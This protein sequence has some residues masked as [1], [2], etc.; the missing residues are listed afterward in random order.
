MTSFALNSTFDTT[1]LFSDIAVKQSLETLWGM[2]RDEANLIV[3]LSALGMGGKKRSVGTKNPYWALDDYPAEKTT[4]SAATGGLVANYVNAS[5]AYTET[6]WYG[7]GTTATGTAGQISL[8]EK[9]F[10]RDD[11]LTIT[12]SNGYSVQLRLG[13]FVSGTGPYMYDIAEIIYTNVASAATSVTFSSGETAVIDGTAVLFDDEA[14]SYLNVKPGVVYNYMQKFR[15]TVGKG[16]FER[17]EMTLANTTL[18]HLAKLGFNSFEKKRNNAL[19]NNKYFLAPT[20][21]GDDRAMFGGF[22]YIFD[23]HDS[24]ACLSTTYKGVNACDTGT[25]LDYGN[26]MTW[27]SN[28]FVKGSKS[29]M[30]FTSPRMAVLLLRA[31]RTEV[32]ITNAAYSNVHPDFPR[33]IGEVPSFETAFGRVYLHVDRGATDI[34]ARVYDDTTTTRVNSPLYWML[35]IDPEQAGIVYYDC[36]EAGGVQTPKIVNVQKTRNSTIDE[37]EFT[38]TMSLFYGDPQTGGYYGITNS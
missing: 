22:P 26:L 23:P 1:N 36:P 8:S 25:T 27:W 24:S 10:Y 17:G 35:G 4:I 2:T 31:I 16:Q 30:L 28:L 19:Y 12:D 32:Q 38:T 18:Q 6:N 34:R 37:I 15:E 7:G 3:T 5:S 33:V 20:S 9:R 29:R 21:G 14:R 11:V 13:D